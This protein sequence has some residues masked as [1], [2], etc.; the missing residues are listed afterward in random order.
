MFRFPNAA[1]RQRNASGNHSFGSSRRHGDSIS[2]CAA[3]DWS[4]GLGCRFQPLES[5]LLSPIMPHD[6]HHIYDRW[7]SFLEGRVTWHFTESTS[8][9][10]LPLPRLSGQSSLEVKPASSLEHLMCFSKADMCSVIHLLLH[11]VRPRDSCRSYH[12]QR[13][14]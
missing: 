11:T 12:E 14:V 5:F 9:L 8:G 7:I 3:L 4:S 10:Q 1:E 6:P 13:Q 2:T